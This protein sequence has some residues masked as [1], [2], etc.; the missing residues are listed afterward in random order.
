[1]AMEIS[2][3]SGTKAIITRSPRR[4][5]PAPLFRPVFGCLSIF[6]LFGGK[7][8]LSRGMAALRFPRLGIETGS[9][10]KN[11]SLPEHKTSISLPTIDLPQL[12]G[13]NVFIP[14]H[15]HSVLRRS[16]YFF[17]FSKGSTVKTSCRGSAVGLRIS[18]SHAATQ[19]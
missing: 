7:E 12:S 18:P 8:S 1:M 9:L 5:I 16:R 14:L 19:T 10:Q 13:P 15:P 3:I 4:D 11:L 2:A 6:H 17:R